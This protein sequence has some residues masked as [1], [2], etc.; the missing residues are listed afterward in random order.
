MAENLYGYCG[1]KCKHEVYSKQEID[2]K[3]AVASGSISMT[4]GEGSV[5]LG[6][7]NGYNV[8]N[9]VVISAG[10][11]YLNANLWAFGA[12]IQT[13]FDINVRLGINDI[14]FTT[15]SEDKVGPTG[16]YECRVVLMKISQ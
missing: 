1:S 3:F 10:I 11:Q 14:K 13:S 9:C 16:T 15:Y 12:G 2:D 8:N 7:P 6:Y 4:N 5:I